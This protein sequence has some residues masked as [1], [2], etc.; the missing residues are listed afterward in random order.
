MNHG[1][2][3]YLCSNGSYFD[4]YEIEAGKV[5]A[6]TA[7]PLYI[8]MSLG[9]WH[10]KLHKIEKQSIIWNVWLDEDIAAIHDQEQSQALKVWKMI[11]LAEY[12][13]ATSRI[14]RLSWM[15]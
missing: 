3:H 13:G 7:Y 2:N 8:L 12:S 10:S 5:A 9:F 14:D 15:M 4:M 11:R 6:G 1:G